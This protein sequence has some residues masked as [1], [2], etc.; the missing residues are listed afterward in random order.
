MII[1]TQNFMMN[2]SDYDNRKIKVFLDDGSTFEGFAAH[3]SRE[4]SYCEFGID[5]ECLQICDYLIKEKE[6]EKV[7]IME[8]APSIRSTEEEMAMLFSVRRS[9]SEHLKRWEDNE[10]PDKYDHNC[11]EYSAQPTQEEFAHALQFQRERGDTFIKLEGNFPLA[12]DFGLSSGIT[13]TMQLSCSTDGWTVNNEIEIKKPAYK[14]LREIELKHFGQV[15][16]E[17]FTVRNIDHLFEYLDFKGAY[18]GEKLVGAYYSYSSNGYTCVDG[19]IVDKDCRH[20]HIATTLLKHAV[21]EVPGNVIFL[22]ADADD[23][24]REMYE[25][26]GFR[27]VDRLYEYLSADI[28]DV[29]P[30]EAELYKEPGILTK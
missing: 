27:E 19:L 14:D 17:D 28:V 15:Y 16:G 26:L 11:F 20:R 8:A 30:C 3:N 10:L 5:A 23:T 9:F 4:Y 22:H 21:S 12:C 6:I 25:K 18:L 24:P 2:L 13:L 7:E 29:G 1:Q